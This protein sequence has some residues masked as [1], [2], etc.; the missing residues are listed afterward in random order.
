LFL[1]LNLDGASLRNSGVKDKV[2]VHGALTLK[3]TQ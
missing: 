1:H 2:G 3:T